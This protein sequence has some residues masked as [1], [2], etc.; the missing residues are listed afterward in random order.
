MTSLIMAMRA[1][2]QVN[3]DKKFGLTISRCLV[4]IL[5]IL[6]QPSLLE[7]TVNNICCF[8]H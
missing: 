8:L 7:T 5:E 3:V 2:Y 1:R 6:A 4:G